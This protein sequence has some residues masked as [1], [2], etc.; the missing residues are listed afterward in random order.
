MKKRRSPAI[1]CWI[2]ASDCSLEQSSLITHTQ[3][4]WVW[5]RIEASWAAN[6]SGGGL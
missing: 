1:A 2:I 5:A 6:R 4:A 3:F